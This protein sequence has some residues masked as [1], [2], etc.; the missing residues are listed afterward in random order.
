LPPQRP[1][2]SL[3]ETSQRLVDLIAKTDRALASASIQG[4]NRLA[5]LLTSTATSGAWRADQRCSR[6]AFKH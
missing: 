2:E 5:P 1:G 3:Y 6:P 4:L